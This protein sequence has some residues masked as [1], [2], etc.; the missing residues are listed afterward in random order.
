VF[1]LGVDVEVRVLLFVL[2]IVLWIT[3]FVCDFLPDELDLFDNVSLFPICW[4]E[5]DS[6]IECDDFLLKVTL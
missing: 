2:L 1:G 4:I 5:L 3:S 6:F